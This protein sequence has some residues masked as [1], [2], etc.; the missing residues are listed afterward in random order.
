[1]RD[2]TL[3]VVLLTGYSSE[4]PP[5]EMMQR[6]DIQGYCDKSRGP[7]ELLV[8]VE[9]SLRHSTV[10]R[11]LEASSRG[12]RQVLSSCLR[13]EERL[14]FQSEI[15][16]ILDEAAEV[17]G[18][19]RAIVALAPPQSDYLP[20]SQLEESSFA[21]AEQAQELRV[22]AGIGP[23]QVGE[24]VESQLGPE[25][26]KTILDAPRLE[27]DLCPDGSA[28]MPLRSDGRWLGAFWVEKSPAVESPQWEILNFFAAQIANRCL[29]RQGAT[30][31]PITGLQSKR[32]W[33]QV[34]LRDLRQAFRFGDPACVVVARLEGLDRVRM[35][36]PRQADAILESMG[37]LIRNSVR[38]TDLCGRGDQDEIVIFLSRTDPEGAARFAELM[39]QRLEEI[40]LPFPDGPRT[41]KGNIGIG[42]L[43][44][45]SFDLTRLPRPMPAEYFPTVERLVRGRAAAAAMEMPSEEQ[46]FPVS[47]HADTFWPDPHE[48]AHSLSRKPQA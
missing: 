44:P 1:V 3:Q 31:D 43:L 10:L 4:K 15:D 20:P 28:V 39:A 17:L 13:Q 24:S 14:S 46:P 25:L 27:G 7:D 33:T 8:W 12:L 45:H 35:L 11:Q 19:E 34:V 48:V 32:F 37:R 18:I 22:I 47:V 21:G 40:L 2:P 29:V 23:C 5:R 42:C 38:G 30:I 9:L 16:S 41:G 26:A 6:L 36:R